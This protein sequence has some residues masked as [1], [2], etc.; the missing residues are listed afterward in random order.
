LATLG[1]ALT[2]EQVRLL[3]AVADKVVLVYDGDA[4]GA[5]AMKRAFPLFAQE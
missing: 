1:T 5:K 4:A 3:K 2:R